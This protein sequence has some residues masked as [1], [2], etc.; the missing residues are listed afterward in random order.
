M[1]GGDEVGAL[2]IDVGT[3][4]TKAGYAG[5]D[6]PKVVIPTAVGIT[7]GGGNGKQSDNSGVRAVS[8]AMEVESASKEDVKMMTTTLPPSATAAV[9]EATP[10]A[11]TKRK[12]K[13]PIN[14]SRKYFIG[15]QGITFR[16]DNMDICKPL[17]NGIVKDW[18]AVEQI[19]NYAFTKHMRVDLKEFPVLVAEPT[20]NPPENRKKLMELLFEKHNSPA[21]FLVKDSVLASF[22]VGKHVALVVDIGGGVTSTVPVHD[23]YVLNKGVR[24]TR[25][26]GEM[27]DVA[28]EQL[29]FRKKD[30][31]LELVPPYLLKKKFDKGALKTSLSTFPNTTASFHRYMCMEV[32][33]D[34]KESICRVADSS[35]NPKDYE[36]VPR[37]SYELPDGKILEIGSERYE[38]SEILFNPGNFNISQDIGGFKFNGIPNM[39]IESI[40]T[41][42][43]DIRRDLFSSIVLTGGSSILPGLPERLNR[44][45]EHSIPSAFKV[46]TIPTSTKSEKCYGVWIGGSILASLGTFHQMWLSKQEYEE[47]G[48]NLLRRKCP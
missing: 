6:L 37:T 18:E 24:K 12:M 46:K 28:L 23:G 4:Y 45:L 47:H 35:F 10:S 30:T 9:S 42:E 5:E 29:L 27:L 43:P 11:D 19:W 17:R 22:A 33:R 21:T 15:S 7:R 13:Q 2:V 14:N 26:A 32:V 16:R 41:C 39:V 8:S 40:N 48:V 34:I 44:D 31:P 20:F 1:Y 25:M 36:N 3:T 38:A